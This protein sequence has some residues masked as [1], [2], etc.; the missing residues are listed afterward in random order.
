MT[1]QFLSWNLKS[2]DHILDQHFFPER[3]KEIKAVLEEFGFEKILTGAYSQLIS[4]KGDK[5]G[6]QALNS[7]VFGTTI[8]SALT[9]INNQVVTITNPDK[10]VFVKQ[11]VAD[12]TF[13]LILE[14]VREIEAELIE[15]APYF[16][17]VLKV[18]CE[19]NGFDYED[20]KNYVN[21]NEL[22]GVSQDLSGTSEAQKLKKV[23]KNTI[24]WGAN[25]ASKAELIDLLK[26]KRDWIR[27]PSNWIKFLTD[28]SDDLQIKWNQTRMEELA[29]LIYKLRE[30][31]LIEC[32]G[33]RGTFS[34]IEKHLV[35]FDGNKLNSGTLKKLSSKINNNW[36]KYE[37]RLKPVT[38]II[39]AVQRKA[40]H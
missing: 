21:L 24:T 38:E 18:S 25:E 32:L 28:P 1:S 27:K 15:A 10:K 6:I 37:H 2:L 22:I 26:K 16:N 29:Y 13:R 33:N 31:G 34:V 4:N 17:D 20:F 12:L 8:T 5:A 3:K 40:R 11:A 36:T 9:Q 7:P 14:L 35:S 23:R 19:L 30:I 39:H